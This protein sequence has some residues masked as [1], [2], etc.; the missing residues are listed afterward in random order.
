MNSSRLRRSLLLSVLVHV[1]VLGIL[2]FISLAELKPRAVSTS[3][4]PVAVQLL[5]LPPQTQPQIAQVPERARKLPEAPVRKPGPEAPK[6]PP[7]PRAPEPVTPKVALPPSQK[8]GTVVDLPKPVREERPD[9]ARLVSRY[10]SK[11]QDIGPGE[12]GTRKPSGEQSRAMPPEI[13][14][15]ERYSTGKPTPPNAVLEPSAPAVSVPP[16]VTP[17][18]PKP[19][20]SPPAKAESAPPKPPAPVLKSEVLPP[21]KPPA[22]APQAKPAPLPRPAPPAAPRTLAEEK[23]RPETPSSTP[24]AQAKAAPRQAESPRAPTEE[25]RQA[26]I[27]PGVNTP[28]VPLAPAQPAI[29]QSQP[30]VPRRTETPLSTPEAPTPSSRVPMSEEQRRARMTAQEELAMLQR[31]PQERERA[32]KSAGSGKQGLDEHFARL[33]KH[34]PL[35]A[36]DAPGVFEQGPERAGEGRGDEEGGKYRSI[37]SFGFKHVSYLLGMQR[38][39]ELVF[40]VPQLRPDHGA[41]GVPIVGFTVRR[42]GEL[43]ETVLIRSSG[44]PAVDQALLRAVQRAAPYSPFPNDMPDQEISIRIYA[45]LS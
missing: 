12:G 30:D 9:D 3:D 25:T 23:R 8:G 38:K 28:Q 37:A 42:N 7:S 14:L 20:G 41:I 24:S 15:P 45:S 43:A 5:D 2:R 39:I 31:T 18:A 13:S 17:A 22:P 33:E 21:P 11:A 10:D 29:P 27:P 32:G 4:A 44:Y 36:F 6:P 16:S 19:P 35:P 40:T 26:A 1:L 34:L